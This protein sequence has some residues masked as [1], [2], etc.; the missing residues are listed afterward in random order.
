MRTGLSRLL[1][2]VLSTAVL[3]TVVVGLWTREQ[4]EIDWSSRVNACLPQAQGGSEAVTECIQTVALAAADRGELRLAAN[5]LTSAAAEDNVFYGICHLALHGLGTRLL[6]K[7]GSVATALPHVNT[8]DCGNGLAHGVFDEWATGNLELDDFREVVDVCQQV[9][10]ATPG[11]CAEGI[12]HAAYQHLP[13]GPDRLS[14]AFPFCEMF[15]EGYVAQHCAYGVVMQPYFKQNDELIDEAALP[16]PLDGELVRMCEQLQRR[17]D[18]VRGCLSGA[19][20]L[21]GLST[22]LRLD[23][24]GLDEQRRFELVSSE[25]F[26]DG[27]SRLVSH[28][29]QARATDLDRGEC[30][31]QLLARLPVEW[32]QDLE[33]LGQRCE[34][35]GRSFVDA[36]RVS[37]LAG[38]YEF[39]S[40]T[41]LELITDRYPEVRDAIRQRHLRERGSEPSR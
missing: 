28:C 12:G 37:C 35:L 38:A 2:A 4:A 24:S 6:E 5:A 21:M 11:G 18:V 13:P 3:G 26:A 17:S 14:A 34:A 7:Y 23:R 39:V 16:I 15:S 8:I 30:T 19:G 1:A 27:V 10:S 22:L 36:T 41:N 33:I 25:Q 20:W 29:A 9:E 40:P 31:S 32:Y